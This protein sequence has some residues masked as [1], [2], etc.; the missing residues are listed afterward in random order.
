MTIVIAAGTGVNMLLGFLLFFAAG[1]G[2]AL[3]TIIENE[4]D[5]KYRG[6]N[7]RGKRSHKSTWVSDHSRC[8]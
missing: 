5:E 7:E 1:F 8:R 2:A 6:M 4:F 3:A